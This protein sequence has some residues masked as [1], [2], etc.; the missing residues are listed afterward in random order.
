MAPEVRQRKLRY[1]EQLLADL[2]PFRHAS[3]AEV[4]QAHYSVE[5]IL[6]L[7]AMTATDLVFHLLAERELCLT[8][9]V[10]SIP[11]CERS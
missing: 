11:S 8:A 10:P 3:P 2:E 1:L 9:W 5:R 7:L 4:E 6:E